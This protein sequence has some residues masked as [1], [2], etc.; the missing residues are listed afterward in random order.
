VG[1]ARRYSLDV[2]LGITPLQG[3]KPVLVKQ[4]E[5]ARRGADQDHRIRKNASREQL[6]A[7]I[8]KLKGDG[9]EIFDVTPDGACFFRCMAKHFEDDQEAHAAY[10]TKV[11]SLLGRYK[12]FIGIFLERKDGES[13]DDAVTRFAAEIQ[14]PR[15]WIG[16]E[17]ISLSALVLGVDIAVHDV[18]H[19]EPVVYR[20]NLPHEPYANP[21]IEGAT[22]RIDV[23]YDGVHYQYLRRRAP[24]MLEL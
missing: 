17:G 2:P 3:N 16:D 20:G 21:T 8:N 19:K 13:V 24:S 14:D 4:L 12:D 18:T 5:E 10:R 1:Q 9:Y 6:D 22:P 11:A 23:F 15:E 7:H